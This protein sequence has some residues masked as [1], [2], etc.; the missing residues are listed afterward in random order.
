EFVEQ[1]VARHIA[2]SEPW[3]QQHDMC[4]VLREHAAPDMLQVVAGDP[5]ELG[6]T[7]RL[8]RGWPGGSA[9]ALH[10][11]EVAALGRNLAAQYREFIH[12]WTVAAHA[13]RRAGRL[14]VSRSR[15][16]PSVPVRAMPVSA[17]PLR[18]PSPSIRAAPVTESRRSR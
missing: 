14:P 13:A 7:S 4:I 16:G 12:T 17:A 15:V 18:A 2:G 11:N 1:P 8:A 9:C 6:G 5:G 3:P 10:G